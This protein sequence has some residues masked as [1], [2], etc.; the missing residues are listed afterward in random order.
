MANETRNFLQM[1]K[2]GLNIVIEKEKLEKIVKL[3]DLDFKKNES[4]EIFHGSF[5]TLDGS[6]SYG[7]GLK[8]LGTIGKALILEST[9][10][11]QNIEQ[12]K[13][14][15]ESSGLDS[16]MINKNDLEFEN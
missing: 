10:F 7:S 4:D 5:C 1:V 16:F 13:E 9:S 8:I 14:K 11:I 6:L 12:I 2:K 3:Y 15:L